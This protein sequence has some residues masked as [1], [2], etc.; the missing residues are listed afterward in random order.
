LIKEINTINEIIEFII[1]INKE[2]NVILAFR[3]EKEDY[4]KTALVPSLYRNKKFIKNEEL[5]YREM[6]RFNDNEFTEDTTTFDKLSRIQH[7]S[8]PTRLLD[9]SEDVMSAIYFAISDKKNNSDAILYIFEIDETKIKY[10][11]S[12]SVSVIS[13]IVKLP[14]T[15]KYKK[16]KTVLLKDIKKYKN[17]KEFNQQSSVKFLIHEIKEEK[18]QFEP[19]IK[20]KDLTSVICV[21][22]KLTNNRLKSQKGFFLLFGLNPDGV[23]KPIQLFKNQ[24]VLKN[25]NVTHPIKKIHK[26][27]IKSCQIEKMQMDLKKLGIT[28]PFIYSEMDQVANYLK[29][30]HS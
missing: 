27:R 22:P 2:K 8:A 15:Y 6:Q 23:D 30:K 11:D 25:Y 20:A 16:S 10:Y 5:I 13:N 3:G 21:R 1:N 29:D 19:I 26:L 7:Y 17:K 24:K 18:P 4:N 12:D 9:I 14:L 28:Q